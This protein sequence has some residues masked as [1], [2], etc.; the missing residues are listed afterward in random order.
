MQTR[1]TARHSQASTGLKTYIEEKVGKLTRYFDRIQ[2]AHVIL[3][4]AQAPDAEKRVEIALSVPNQTFNASETGPTHR[5]AING[6]VRQLKRQVVR[7]KDKLRD[8]KGAG[9]PRP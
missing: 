5:V 4:D 7:H 3:E 1:I 2:D 8:K 9:L 6:A